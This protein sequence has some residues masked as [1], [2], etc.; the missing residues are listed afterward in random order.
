MQYLVEQG[1]ISA[2]CNVFIC[3]DVGVVRVALEA[4]DKI[5]RTGKR[6]ADIKAASERVD[7]LL[8]TDKTMTDKST[9]SVNPWAAMMV[10]SGGLDQLK[11][12]AVRMQEHES[13]DIYQT[14]QSLLTL[15]F[16]DN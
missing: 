4:I 3:A 9:R 7:N 5:M 15:Y 6:M 8:R 1:I 2:F 14:A 13:T 12:L 11:A 16:F 10:E